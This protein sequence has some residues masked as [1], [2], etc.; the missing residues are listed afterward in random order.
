MAP[1]KPIENVCNLFLIPL[2][3]Y[4]LHIIPDTKL[5]SNPPDNKA[6]I[7]LSD[8]NL[9]LTALINLLLIHVKINSSG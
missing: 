8:N 9:F 3:L 7:G 5:L 2:S 6:P 4:N 1:V